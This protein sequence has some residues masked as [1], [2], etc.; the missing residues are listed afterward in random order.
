MKQLQWNHLL[1]TN[2]NVF[3]VTYIA[4]TLCKA[5]LMLTGC[6]VERALKLQSTIVLPTSLSFLLETPAALLFTSTHSHCKR[7]PHLQDWPGEPNPCFNVAIKQSHTVG[8]FFFFELCYHATLSK[9]SCNITLK[10]IF[11]L[12]HKHCNITVNTIY[13]FERYKR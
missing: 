6:L 12:L 1:V 8:F 10:V 13:I 2:R 5:E 7:R 4:V 3:P 11:C 9:T